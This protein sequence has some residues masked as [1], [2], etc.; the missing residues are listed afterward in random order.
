M[1]IGNKC[2]LDDYREVTLEESEKFA[3]H[4]NVEDVLETSAKV[5]LQLL[6]F[7]L[8][9]VHQVMYPHFF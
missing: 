3:K 9:L 5:F 7:F 8:N 2:D 4:F 6:K 1:M